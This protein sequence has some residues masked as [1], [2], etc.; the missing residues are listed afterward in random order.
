M[1][2]QI[3]TQ[4]PH[5]KRMVAI[6][7]LYLICSSTPHL[8]SPL[9]VHVHPISP[10]KARSKIAT[11]LLD[12]HVSDLPLKNGVK[13]ATPLFFAIR[14]KN[15]RVPLNMHQPIP[16]DRFPHAN[17]THWKISLPLVGLLATWKVIDNWLS[18]VRWCPPVSTPFT[19]NWSYH[20]LCSCFS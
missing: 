1:F 8:R 9:K 12:W 20:N 14:C 7:S 17:R 10:W 19:K 18:L 5:Y 2:Q 3:R 6:F 11:P 15:Q 13:D 4:Q 16:S